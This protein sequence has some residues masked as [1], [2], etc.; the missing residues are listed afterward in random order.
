[1]CWWTEF[2]STWHER[3]LFLAK[4]DHGMILITDGRVVDIDKSICLSRFVIRRR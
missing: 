2:L 4:A 3:K 1:M